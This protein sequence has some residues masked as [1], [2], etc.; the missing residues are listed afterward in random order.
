[1]T[2]AKTMCPLIISVIRSLAE[3]VV[4]CMC[5]W[6]RLWRLVN[7]DDEGTSMLRCLNICNLLNIRDGFCGSSGMCGVANS[8]SAFL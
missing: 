5:T 8:K 7:G 1:M 3:D 4:L 6:L 2:S